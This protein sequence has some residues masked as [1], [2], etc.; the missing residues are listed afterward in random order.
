MKKNEG[1]FGFIGLVFTCLILL[2]VSIYAGGPNL[3]LNEVESDPPNDVGDRCQ[4]VEIKGVGIVPGGTIPANTYFISINSDSSNFGFLNTAVNI[5]GQTLGSNGTLT[6][7][8][9]VGGVCPNRMLDAGTTV[10]NY[11]SGTTLGQGSE[12]FYIVTSAT[13]LAGGQDLDADDNGVVDVSITYDDGFNYIFNPDEQFKYGPGPILNESF[14]GDVPDAAT[15]FPGNTQANNAG[16]W[17]S[18]ELASSPEETTTY[19]APFSSNFP[20]GGMLTP[21]GTNVPAMMMTPRSRADFDGDGR[22]DL[23]VFRPSQGN[24]YILGSTAGFSVLNWGLSGDTLVPGDYDNDGKS[25]TAIFRPTNNPGADFYILNS[26]G[27]TFT[28]LDW[29]NT[30]DIPVVG[31]Y[32]G[33]QKADVA[34]FRPSN[35][36]WYI[37]NS[38]GGATITPFGSTGDVPLVADWDGDG[39]TDLS[40]RRGINWIASLSAGGSVNVPFGLAG[41][42]AVQADYDG[43]NKDDI[44]VFRPSNGTWYA[45]LSSTGSPIQ[46]QFGAMGDIPVPGDFDGDGVDDQAIYRNGQWW[47]NATTAGVSVSS[48]GL[49]SDQPVPKAYLP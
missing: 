13:A 11:F 4:Y 12:G 42:L 20:T 23:S 47:I 25:D 19:A 24:W 27:F 2:N 30:G 31:D 21:G 41:D 29:G 14:G 5:S 46:I 10:L 38:S 39:K 7:I 6:L 16:A 28:G 37:L 3:L 43:D 17:Y 44:T 35:N 45:L 32:D 36:T 18:G 48:F 33:D 22:T 9:T 49:A 15:R 40:V 34:V 26:N 1:L 8:N